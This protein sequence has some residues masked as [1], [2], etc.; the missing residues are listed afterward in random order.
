MHTD[1]NTLKLSQASSFSGTR[2][3]PGQNSTFP[4]S[5]VCRVENLKIQGKQFLPK[6][7]T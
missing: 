3:E 6:A 2:T 1:S 7:S 4:S 5:S